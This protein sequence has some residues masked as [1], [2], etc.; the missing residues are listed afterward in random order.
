MFSFHKFDYI[1]TVQLLQLNCWYSVVLSFY[2]AAERINQQWSM[3]G[4]VLN[5]GDINSDVF[6]SVV[7]EGLDFYYQQ[8]QDARKLVEFLQSVV[9][10]R[11]V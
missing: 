8:Q 7:L 3:T 2:S 1:N 10:C 11:Y 4:L 9:P 6:F 5:A